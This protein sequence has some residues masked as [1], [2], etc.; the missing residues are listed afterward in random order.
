MSSNTTAGPSSRDR[1]FGEGRSAPVVPQHVRAAIVAAVHGRE[2]EAAHV[3]R[4]L[5]ALVVEVRDEEGG[6]RGGEVLL[7]PRRRAR[8]VAQ[9]VADEGDRG[10]P[11]NALNSIFD[12]GP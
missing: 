4:D 5:S 11:P 1:E 3:A 10:G 9:P 2:A 12:P 8:L 6:V 7:V